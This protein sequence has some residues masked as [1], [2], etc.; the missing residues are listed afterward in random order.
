MDI[1]QL[2]QKDMKYISF[3]LIF[4]VESIISL[5]CGVCIIKGVIKGFTELEYEPR[6]E[7]ST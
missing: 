6:R 7:I 1:L 5:S 4:L 2:T 3:I